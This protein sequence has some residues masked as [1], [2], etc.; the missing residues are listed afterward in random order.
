MTIRI[1]NT[2][3]QEKDL[4]TGFYQHHGGSYYHTCRSCKINQNK[5]HVPVPKVMGFARLPEATKEIVYQGLREGK[6]CSQI[7]R[8]TGLKYHTLHSWIKTDQ[9]HPMLA[10]QNAVDPMMEYELNRMRGL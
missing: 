8:E 2:C 6:R 3:N 1:C 9:V 10:R 4:L 5:R 7:S